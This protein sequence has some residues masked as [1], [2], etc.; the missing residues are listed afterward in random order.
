MR[1]RTKWRTHVTIRIQQQRY[2]T[3][4]GLGCC[5]RT[6]HLQRGKREQLSCTRFVFE[7]QTKVLPLKLYTTPTTA[8]VLMSDKCRIDDDMCQMYYT[9]M[10]PVQTL[11]C[12]VLPAC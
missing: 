11:C 10:Q 9:L 2:S 1:A 4:G 8:R 6:L 7:V 12:G 3:C 5:G